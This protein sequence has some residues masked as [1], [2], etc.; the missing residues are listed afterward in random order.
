MHALRFVDELW[1][2]KEEQDHVIYSFFPFSIVL[3]YNVGVDVP[4]NHIVSGFDSYA[5]TLEQYL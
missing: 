5:V 1:K 2:N 3:L 4:D